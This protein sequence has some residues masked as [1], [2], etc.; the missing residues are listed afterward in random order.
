[1]LKLSD[2]TTQLGIYTALFKVAMEQ[3][4]KSDDPTTVG[5]CLLS[6]GYFLYR[7]E[8]HSH[9]RIRWMLNEICNQSIKA[10]KE[11]KESV[12]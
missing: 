5:A 2:N 12:L 6:L 7:Q 10:E 3:R 1:M 4:K 11:M 9:K 8:G